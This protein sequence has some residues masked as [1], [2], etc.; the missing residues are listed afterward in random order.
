MAA[1]AKD[2]RCKLEMSLDL[3]L[4]CLYSN[5]DEGPTS[6][7]CITNSVLGVA[8]NKCFLFGNQTDNLMNSRSAMFKQ[9]SK[10]NQTSFHKVVREHL[11]VW[12]VA[13]RSFELMFVRA[14]S[15]RKQAGF[16]SRFSFLRAE[17]RRNY[18]LPPYFV[19]AFSV[20]LVVVHLSRP[21]K[22]KRWSRNVRLMAQ[23]T[24][25][26]RNWKCKHPL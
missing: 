17:P 13:Q 19:A 15:R 25:K 23:L 6:P 22:L 3:K 14:W 7:T 24:F 9:C 1:C 26:G 12:N 16:W 20:I 5:D 4:T 11:W 2:L 8:D 21:F 18:F 10:R